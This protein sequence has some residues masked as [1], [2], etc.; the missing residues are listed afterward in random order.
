[1][2]NSFVQQILVGAVI[3]IGSKLLL[4]LWELIK[5]NFLIYPVNSK[6][7]NPKNVKAQFYIFF[8]IGILC[9]ILLPFFKGTAEFYSGLFSF[10]G[11]FGVWRAFNS[12]MKCWENNVDNPINKKPNNKSN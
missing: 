6:T 1:M 3:T 12:S 2:N 4:K 9:L 8:A 11:F 7:Q 5:E 10:T